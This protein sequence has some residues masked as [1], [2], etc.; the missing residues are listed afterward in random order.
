[1]WSSHFLHPPERPCVGLSLS[2]PIACSYWKNAKTEGS[3]GKLLEGS[4]AQKLMR[5]PDDRL[6]PLWEGMLPGRGTWDTCRV[7]GSGAPQAGVPVEPTP[8]SA[9]SLQSAGD[10]PPPHDPGDSKEEGGKAPTQQP[11]AGPLRSTAPRQ[12]LPSWVRWRETCLQSMWEAVRRL[13]WGLLR[14]ES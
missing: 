8:C 4:K 2:S 5:T 12:G 3:R 11:S 6:V 9:V 10:E 14:E 13:A 1:M 7:L